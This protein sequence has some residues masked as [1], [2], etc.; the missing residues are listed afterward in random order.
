MTAERLDCQAVR[1]QANQAMGCP[2]HTR[3]SRPALGLS[4][5][6]VRATGQNREGEG[7]QDRA[8]E[9]TERAEPSKTE[10]PAFKEKEQD[11]AK[12]FLTS[13][14]P[15]ELFTVAWRP[16][17][18]K[19]VGQVL[20]FKRNKLVITHPL[21]IKRTLQPSGEKI[22]EGERN[23]QEN[24][25]STLKWKGYGA[26]IHREMRPAGECP[27]HPRRPDLI[28]DFRSRPSTRMRVPAAP[29]QEGA[30]PHH[31]K[32]DSRNPWSSTACS[33]QLATP[34]LLRPF[35]RQGHCHVNPVN[36]CL[37]ESVLW[38]TTLD[39]PCLVS[40][41]GATDSSVLCSS[42]LLRSASAS[43]SPQST[44]QSHARILQ[45]PRMAGWPSPREHHPAGN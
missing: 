5:D 25:S 2:S 27:G 23:A 14:Q 16:P 44:G 31:S 39:E 4:V 6:K 12:H 3:P 21:R 15:Y 19:G 42:R 20:P 24:G 37:S 41:P 1:T 35:L 45:A 33:D 18:Y 36:R 26:V 8:T 38:Q 22:T 34:Q 29:S 11:P 40:P 43:T 28:W 13:Q 10:E 9:A 7:A 17:T 30:S 32:A